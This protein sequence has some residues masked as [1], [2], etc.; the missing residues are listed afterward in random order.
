M[1]SLRIKVICVSLAALL[2]IIGLS[3]FWHVP[4]ILADTAAVGLDYLTLSR[5]LPK[6]QKKQMK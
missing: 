4:K 6:I 5:D 2:L 3:S 1:R